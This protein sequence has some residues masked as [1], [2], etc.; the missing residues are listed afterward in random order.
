MTE[1]T[2]PA[3]DAATKPAK[4]KGKKKL[5]LLLAVVPVV[6][7]GGGAAA[8]FF[9]PAVSHMVD[10]LIGRHPAGAEAAT[11]AVTP[12][13]TPPAPRPQFI[14]LPEMAVTMPN[15]G[16][17]RQL[18]IKLA[19]EL[20]RATPT[21]PDVPAAEVL[22]PRVLDALLAYLR[23]LRDADTE[24]G[25]ALDRIRGDL[26]RRLTLILGPDIIQDVLVT[27]LVLA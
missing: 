10:P 9:V 13:A 2:P 12:P 7:G 15:G 18:R 1:A 16:R 24:G 27:S 5:L 23:T 26:Y 8:Y 21:S 19:L 20:T 3:G 17:P 4:S 6:L 11:A 14:E 25:L 22:T